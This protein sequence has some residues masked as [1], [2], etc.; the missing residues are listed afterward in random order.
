[1]SV[2]LNVRVQAVLCADDD[3]GNAATVT[4]MGFAQRVEAAN[5]IYAPVGITFHFDPAVDLVQVQS[6]LLN[7]SLTVLEPPDVGDDG[8]STKPEVDTASHNRAREDFGRI[9][10]RKIVVF[11][12]QLTQ[13][14]QVGSTWKI[15]SAPNSSSWASWYI[16]LSQSGAGVGT[17]AHE[18]GHYLQIRHT[19]SGATTVAEA[20]AVIKAKVNDGTYSMADGLLALDAD[21]V[22]VV[23]TPSDC[24]PAIF[25]DA[26]VPPCG[27]EGVQIKVDFGQTTKEYLLKPDQLNVMSYHGCSGTKTIS[28]QQRRRVRDGLE[29]GMRQRLVSMRG[30]GREILALNGSAAAGLIGR[31]DVVALG[32]GRAVTP[33]SDGNDKLKVIAWDVSDAGEIERRGDALAGGVDGIRACAIGLGMLATA[34]RT[35]S[36]ALKVII[37][38]VDNA[39]NV[40]RKGDAT[41]QQVS[42]VS[43]C[44]VGIEELATATRRSDGTLGI[45][46][47]HV[48]AGGEITLLAQASAGAI[49]YTPPTI[50]LFPVGPNGFAASVRNAD[51]QLVTILWRYDRATKALERKAKLVYTDKGM[52]VTACALDSELAITA[53]RVANGTLKLHGQS[54]SY[55]SEYAV[56][57]GTATAG[58][59]NSLA[60]CRVG[61]EHVVTGVSTSPNNVKLIAWNVSPSGDAIMRR[62]S[63]MLGGVQHV[64]L[65]QIGTHQ[66]LVAARTA[67]QNL[68]LTAWDL[69]APLQ[70]QLGV[71]LTY[72]LY[73][74]FLQPF[75]RVKFDAERA[76][77]CL[78]SVV[79]EATWGAHLERGRLPTVTTR[80][81]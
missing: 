53:I 46:L 72:T 63:A 76:T 26:G 45:D 56:V 73:D 29:I 28:A 62:D 27:S 49:A 75:R 54:F 9:F 58:A 14:D 41:G 55:D 79:D 33:V 34:V 31:Y 15:G 24:K 38:K 65:C 17:L 11:C 13:L 39:G 66:L 78:A 59:I 20:A 80:P 40:T 35:A 48:T 5:A 23:D 16:N 51:G 74:A 50:G 3:G 47:W 36:G 43:I 57:R 61:V 64:R 21:R 18:L 77:D 4:P 12:R 69:R 70:L 81:S 44:R 52:Y 1:M 7:R 60:M 68:A 37:W 19:F 2:P 8:W 22:W 71:D 6:T 10:S 67:Q 32:Y 30:T 25:T 42:E